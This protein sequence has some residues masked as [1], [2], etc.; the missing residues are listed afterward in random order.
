MPIMNAPQN[1]SND[2]SRWIPLLLQIW[3]KARHN[4][5]GPREQLTASEASEV[6]QGVQYLSQ[7]LTRDRALIGE[8]YL[9]DT[10]LLG[11]YLLYFW[12]LSYLQAREIFRHLPSTPRSV[13]DLGSGPGPL[14]AAAFDEG[15]KTV[16]FTDRSLPALKLAMELA[17]AAGKNAEFQNWDPIKHPLL[18]RA[19]YDC[20][21]AE[22]LLNELW[23]DFS[24][25]VEKRTELV[26]PWFE[27]LKSGG[28]VVLIEPALT[29]TSRDLMGVRDHLVQQ[30]YRLIYPC[31]CTQTPCPALAKPEETCHLEQ[32]WNLPPL[33]RD[34]VRR[35][36][37]KKKTL[38]MT[39]FVFSGTDSTPLTLPAELFRIVS[40]PLLSKN[41]RIRLIGCSQSG[42]L[43]LALK[44]ELATPENRIF[45]TLKRG[46][47]VRILHA[48]PREGGSGLDLLPGSVVELISRID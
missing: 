33:I 22:H 26:L 41:K 9:S 20:I 31:L 21:A 14:G 7:G 19:K 30:G 16:T 42:R 32:T 34:L 36:D 28:H 38:K 24:N 6:S 23:D 8:R 47:V 35:L 1:A 39:A 25:R 17:K 15:A 29:T 11:A 40:D 10:V 12:P 4:K 27:R 43:S 2:L 37:F 44:P 48:S 18:P 3:R 13:L 45:L 46:D 5:S